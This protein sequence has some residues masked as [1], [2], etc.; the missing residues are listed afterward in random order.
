MF[1]VIKTGLETSVQDYPG[2]IGFGIKVSHH[3]AQWI[4]GHFV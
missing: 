4:V 3:Q 1:T 2:R